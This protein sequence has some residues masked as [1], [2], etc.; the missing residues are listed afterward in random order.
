MGMAPAGTQLQRAHDD[1]GQ[2]VDN[3]N[4][5]SRKYAHGRVHH[6]N[7]HMHAPHQG[8]PGWGGALAAMAR[9][10]FLC[11]YVKDPEVG[12]ARVRKKNCNSNSGR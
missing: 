9:V 1:G 2:Q 5:R 6:D 8:N 10:H 4:G 12:P 11:K 7:T 3:G